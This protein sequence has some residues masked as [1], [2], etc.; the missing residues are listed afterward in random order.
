M[1]DRYYEKHGRDRNDLLTNSGVVFQT[2]AF[3]L[4]NIRALQQLPLDRDNARVLD[5]GCGTGASL[6]QFL[7]LGF[8]PGNLTGIDSSAERI[9]QARASFPNM[10]FRCE[11][12]DSMGFADSTFDIVFESTLFMMLTVEEEAQRIAREMLRVT[13]PGGYLMLADWRY[14]KRRSADHRAMSR[15]RIAS[16]FDVRR[17]TEVVARERGALVPPL[18]RLLSRRAPSLY[19]AVQTLLPFTVGQVTTVLRKRHLNARL[20]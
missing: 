2:F 9:A 18:G 19:F 20:R 15:K 14:S 7:R 1:Y 4:A 6:L 13:R 17:A 16:L 5:V 11:S 3:D 12:A 8:R 10:N